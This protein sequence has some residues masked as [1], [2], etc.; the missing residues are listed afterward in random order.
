MAALPW[1]LD[2]S[3]NGL[4]QTDSAAYDHTL[5]NSWWAKGTVVS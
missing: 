4:G 5:E 3:H 2:I 1:P